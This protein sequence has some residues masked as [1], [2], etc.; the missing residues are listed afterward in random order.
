[1][2]GIGSVA[3]DGVV[4]ATYPGNSNDPDAVPGVAPRPEGD[5]D[6]SL[7]LQVDGEVF[8]LRADAPGRGTHYTW[9]SGRNPGYG[10]T[11]SPTGDMPE[12]GH[13][14][15]IRDFLAQIDPATG[16]IAED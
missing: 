5:G 8:T 4:W 11:V 14:E 16:Y 9:V 7:T 12:E 6:P 15:N 2:D 13:R 3:D 1:M 10:F